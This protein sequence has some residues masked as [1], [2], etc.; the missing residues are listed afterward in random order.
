MQLFAV[1]G[2]VVTVNHMIGIVLAAGGVLLVVRSRSRRF[3]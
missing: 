1:G 2:V 3:D